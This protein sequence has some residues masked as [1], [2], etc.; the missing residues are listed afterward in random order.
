M[1]VRIEIIHCGYSKIPLEKVYL[2]MIYC[3]FNECWNVLEFP[4]SL[5][6]HSPVRIRIQ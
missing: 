6:V 5:H 4:A 2:S 3:V 1:D